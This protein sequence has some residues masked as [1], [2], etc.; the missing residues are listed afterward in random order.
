MYI[1]AYLPI[2]PVRVPAISMPTEGTHRDRRVDYLNIALLDKNFARL[3]AEALH[4]IFRDNL[5]P[6]ELLNLPDSGK[7]GM[8]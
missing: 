2:H 5:A 4:L 1:P 6:R 8:R 7:R 3:E